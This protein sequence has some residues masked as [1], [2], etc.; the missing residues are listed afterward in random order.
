MPIIAPFSQNATVGR[1]FYEIVSNMRVMP[2]TQ[3]PAR[4]RGRPAK[5]TLSL[6]KEAVRRRDRGES[7]QEIAEAMG[8]GLTTV[9]KA[10]EIGRN[11]AG[12]QDSA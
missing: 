3:A 12:I 6:I 4:G 10:L 11:A 9:Y 1:L 5:L 7:P 2:D 8:L